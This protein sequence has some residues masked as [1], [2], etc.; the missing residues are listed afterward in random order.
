ME[1]TLTMAAPSASVELPA[2]AAIMLDHNKL[3]NVLATAPH[4]KHKLSSSEAKTNLICKYA[5]VI[6][7]T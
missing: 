6:A 4:R 1:H 5:Y 7:A 3:L 2:N